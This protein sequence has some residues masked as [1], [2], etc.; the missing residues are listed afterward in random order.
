MRQHD[1]KLHASRAILKLVME[2][3]PRHDGSETEPGRVENEGTP[4][5]LDVIDVQVRDILDRPAGWNGPGS[6]PVR[7]TTL[8]TLLG[9]LT[10]LELSAE[11]VPQLV[12]IS[13]GGVQAEWHFDDRSIEVG[14]GSDG[15]LFAF[16]VHGNTYDLAVEN[17][18]QLQ[19]ETVQGL[20]SYVHHLGQG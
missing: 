10:R 5:W 7:Q 20:A 8:E 11:N 13:S 12:A 1:S 15:Q 14:V 19:D 2:N 16:V 4:D 3:L 6:R 17:V 18:Q 9:I